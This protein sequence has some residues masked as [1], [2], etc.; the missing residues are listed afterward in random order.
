MKYRVGALVTSAIYE[1]IEA[2]SPEEAKEIMADMHGDESISL[3]AKCSKKISGLAV[4]ENTEDYEVE[5]I[6]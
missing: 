5:E 4:S 2:D 3:C 1:I 6:K